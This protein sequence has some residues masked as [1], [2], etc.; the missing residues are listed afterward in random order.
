[1]ADEIRNRLASLKGVEVIARGSSTPYKKTSKTPQ[2]IARELDAQYLLT[3]TLRWQ[4]SGGGSRVHVVPELVEVR[5]ARAPTS[6][7]RQSFDAAITDVFQVQ[8]DVATSVAQALGGA[9]GASDEK[10]LAAS[11]THN[12]AAYDAYLKGE[13]ASQGMSTNDPASVRKALGFYEQ[14]VAMDPGF[15]QAWASLS[16]ANAS[17]YFN[18]SPTPELAERARQAGEKALALAPDRQ[19]GYLALGAY[20]RLVRGE[21]ARALAYYERGLRAAPNVDSLLRGQA[22]AEQG[23]GR[24]DVALQHFKQAERLDP[25][26]VRNLT[27]VGQALLRL[28]RYAEAREAYD[29]ALALA[30]ANLDLVI[31]KITSY[32]GQGDLAGAR[33]VLRAVPR[34]VEPTALVA[35]VASIQDLVW[36]LDEPQRELL[37]RLTPSAF[38]D[39]R[40][41]WAMCFMQAYGFRGD[42]AEARRYAE[43]ARKAFEAQLRAAPNDAQL[44]AELGLALAYLGRKDEAIREGER[45]VALA[46]VSKNAFVG[47]YIQHQLAR[48]HMLVGEP[49][50]ALLQLEPL[51]KMPFYLSPA[52][53]KIDPNFEPLRQNPRFQ[54]LIAGAA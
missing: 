7:W 41:A 10:R 45:G 39:D 54:S 44:H 46:P 1:M 2:E 33:A 17:L 50:K 42:A 6:K 32:L 28:R 47:P 37:L 27:Y 9:L 51:L 21:H 8:S 20:E 53:L 48:I 11:S 35:N 12:V 38:D 43:E 5:G 49:E 26:S 23:L 40:G 3:A 24:W 18:S 34:D 16:W 19:D 31:G 52:W 22:L 36:V 29:R 13:A 25:R 15:A 30:P 14:A 4:K